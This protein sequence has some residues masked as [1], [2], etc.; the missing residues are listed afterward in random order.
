MQLINGKIVLGRKVCWRCH[1]G[2]I[3]GKV[4]CPECKGS[5][6]GKRG[7]RGGCRR[8]NGNCTVYSAD[9]MEECYECK[10]K[11]IDYEAETLCDYMPKDIWA[12]VPL[13]VYRTNKPM[14]V[15]EYLLGMGCLFSC[16]DYGRAWGSTD[17]QVLESV[18]KHDSVQATKVCAD[19][20]RLCSHVGIFINEGGYTVKAVFEHCDVCDSMGCRS[21]QHTYE[22]A[23]L[24]RL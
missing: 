12:Q 1:E 21:G 10:G 9:V 17:E 11:Y 7:G 5:G 22:G 19:D 23:C 14:T 13:K 20:G 8:C 4:C 24:C 18:R 3:A 15:G 16:T 6:N 2:Q